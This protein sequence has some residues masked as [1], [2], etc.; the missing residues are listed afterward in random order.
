ADAHFIIVAP[1]CHKQIRRE[2]RGSNPPTELAFL[3]RFGTYQERLSEMVTDSMRAQLIELSG[4]DSNL[5]EFISDAHTPKNVM[6]VGQKRSGV[7]GAEAVTRIKAEIERAKLTFG[8]QTHHL[9][10]LLQG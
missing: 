3:L 9:E 4:Y 8:I 2:M 10:R 6:I 1:C 5:F 7:R